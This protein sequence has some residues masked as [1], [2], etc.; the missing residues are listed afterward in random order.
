LFLLCAAGRSLVGRRLK[1]YLFECRYCVCVCVCSYKYP[2][3][4]ANNR[5]TNNL[6]EKEQMNARPSGLAATPS[7]TDSTVRIAIP[8]RISQRVRLLPLF[9]SMSPP[10]PVWFF[11]FQRV[12]LTVHFLL[13]GEKMGTAERRRQRRLRIK[14]PTELSPWVGHYHIGREGGCSSIAPGPYTHTLRIKHACVSL[15]VCIIYI[16]QRYKRKEKNKIPRKH[17]RNEQ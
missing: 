1:I 11:S 13:S 10:L 4:L 6:Q 3:E 17:W 12:D 5:H 7:T 14:K 2:M 15:C 8:K 9:P 16:F